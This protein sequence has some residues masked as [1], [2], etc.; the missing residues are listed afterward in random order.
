MAEIPRIRFERTGLPGLLLVQ[1]VASTDARGTFTKTFHAE[2]YARVGLPAIFA[3]EFH[4]VS[5]RGVIRGLHFQAPPHDH[6]KTVFCTRGEVFDVVIDLRVG[7]PTYG[8]VLTCDLN[9]SDGLGLFVPRGCAHGFAAMSDGATLAYKVT[10]AYAPESDAGVLWSSVGVEWP[11][12]APLISARDASFPSLRD[13]DSPFAYEG[14][15][16]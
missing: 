13:F 7:S 10:A 14:E 9:D 11:F 8:E 6:D 16:L 5:K 2:A 1:G 3:E 4:T 15:R 12:E